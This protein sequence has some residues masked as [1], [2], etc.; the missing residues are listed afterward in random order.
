MSDT[1]NEVESPEAQTDKCRTCK[2]WF[3]KPTPGTED[4]DGPE[5]GQCKRNPPL[6][7]T[8]ENTTYTGFPMIVGDEWC[9]EHKNK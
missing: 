9:G 4:G 3:Y 5:F 2:Y 7:L 8:L 6:L 1:N